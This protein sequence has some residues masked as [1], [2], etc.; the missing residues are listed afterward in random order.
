[1]T[2][3][4]A[5]PRTPTAPIAPRRASSAG[6]FL[7]QPQAVH[8]VGIG[9]SGMSGLAECLLRC[10]FPVSGSDAV[11]G[12]VSQR[13][14]QL[15]AAVS[16][17]HRAENVPAG[18]Q[19][20]VRTLAVNR[21]NPEVARAEALGLPVICYADLLGRV[22]ADRF[23]I[24]VSGCH[25]KTTTTAMISHALHEL[26]QDPSF[27]VGGVLTGFA[28][29]S[30]VGNGPHFV[31]EACEYARS[32]H[33]LH[34]RVAVITNIEADHLD[35][36][37]DLDEIVE[38]FAEFLSHVPQTGAW[39]TNGDDPEARRAVTL[40]RQRHGARARAITFGRSPGCDWRLLEPEV[41][42]GVGTALVS[43]PGHPQVPLRL[44]Q[45]GVHNLWNAT[46]AIAALAESGLAPSQVARALQNFGGVARR[47]QRLAARDGSV[48]M[49]DYAHHPTEVD[50]VLKA[51]RRL[52]G[53][54]R[55]IAIYQPHQ[56]GRTHRHLHEFGN[57]LTQADQVLIPDIY[58]ARET[59]ADRRAVSV[60]DLVREV[61]A[62]GGHAEHVPATA[63]L[64]ARVRAQLHPGTLVVT[65][66]AGDVWKIAEELR[67]TLFS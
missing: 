28:T 38:S 47:M 1:M 20:V 61:T 33:Y 58:S 56:H 39:V 6:G 26:G 59:E 16:V 23:G 34:A 10:G 12:S 32:F 17:G 48:L 51:A 25:G 50:A 43:G 63:D 8:F 22:M 40:A 64:I 2:P 45:P 53:I 52:P 24:A 21:E 35:Y 44:S 19:L 14:A 5:A 42:D 3:T 15:G 41:V 31:A 29:S 9:G 7:S 55:I 60:E 13:L 11:A 65:M 36:Y 67:R 46:A 27:V 30:R 66:G 4:P 49:D 57:V 54:S 18:A 37:R 62:H